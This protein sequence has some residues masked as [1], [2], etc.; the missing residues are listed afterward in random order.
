MQNIPILN[1]YICPNNPA[2][3]CSV[4]KTYFPLQHEAEEKKSPTGTWPKVL[5]HIVN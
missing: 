3:C 1:R 5:F 2:I 4:K